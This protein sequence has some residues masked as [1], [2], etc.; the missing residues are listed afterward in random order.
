MTPHSMRKPPRLTA[1]AAVCILGLSL[2]APLASAQPGKS[3][4]GPQAGGAPAPDGGPGASNAANVPGVVVQAPRGPEQGPPIPADKK[5]A[6][7]E[8]VAKAEAWKRYRQATPP[9]SDGTLGQAKGYPGLQSL[10]PQPEPS[11]GR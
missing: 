3:D 10:L 7:D 2:S 1:I 9:L 5:A 8:E 11:E 6:Y 4:S